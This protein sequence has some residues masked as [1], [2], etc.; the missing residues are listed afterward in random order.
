MIILKILGTLVLAAICGILFRFGG[1]SNVGARWLRQIGVEMTELGALFLWFGW[2]WW[3]I[4]VT[5]LAWTECTYFKSKGSSAQWWNWLICAIQ[6]A[7]IPLPLAF[8]GIISWWGFLDRSLVII[9]V[10]TLWRTFIGDVDW[11]EGG[12]GAWQLI[13]IPLLALKHVLWF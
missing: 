5:A 9:P 6:Y 3:L 13:T 7:L 10:I 1:S 12:C 2:S 4:P 8:L 11:S